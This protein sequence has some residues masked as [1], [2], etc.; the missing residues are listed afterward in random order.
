M[1]PKPM[2]INPDYLFPR[3]VKTYQISY[4]NCAR[5]NPCRNAIMFCIF[6]TDQGSIFPN[7]KPVARKEALEYITII[8][9]NRLARG[10]KITIH[11]CLRSGTLSD[12]E[13]K[14]PKKCEFS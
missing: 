6:N 14:S 9:S 12:K 4:E 11:I 5:I 8:R 2:A 10:T 1:L 13:T 7:L 3:C